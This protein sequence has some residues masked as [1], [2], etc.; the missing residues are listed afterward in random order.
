MPFLNKVLF[1]IITITYISTIYNP[2]FCQN[3][4]KKQITTVVIDAGHGGHD[5]GSIG[6]NSKEKDITLGVALKLGNYI[7]KYLPDVKVIFTRT[8]DVYVELAKRAEI[9]NK[10]QA[11]LFISIH[12]NSTKKNIAKGTETFVMG[13]SKSDENLEVAR[14]ENSVIE[15]EDDYKNKYDGFDP[16][17]AE[18][19]II[20]SLVQSTFLQQSTEFAA[21]VQDQFTNKAQRFNRGLKQAGFLVLW[22]TTMPSV[23]VETGFISNPEEE[24]FLMSQKGQEILSSSIFRA[25]KKYKDK[26]ENKSFYVIEPKIDD[27]SAIIPEQNV[28]I[29][30]DSNLPE[31]KQDTFHQSDI[32]I[33]SPAA[34]FYIQVAASQKPIS[35]NS[36]YF[37]G[38]NNIKELKSGNTYKYLI[39]PKNNYDDII[40]YSKVVKNYFPDAFIVALSNNKII[41]LKDALKEIKD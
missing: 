6:K 39:G 34:D 29:I 10:N 30:S 22:R 7:K 36:S 25:F 2:S 40:E 20:F 23:L 18:S 4:V 5:P 41:P 15:L 28:S 33:E 19:Y 13:Y 37:K 11:D 27:S 3:H 31:I 1:V 24:K 26:I 17:S 12:V 38:F 21:L 14:K 9:A 8:T 35:F 16:N 32:N